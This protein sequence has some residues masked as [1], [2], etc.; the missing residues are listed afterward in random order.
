VTVTDSTGATAA[1]LV[2]GAVATDDTG[3][4]APADTNAQFLFTPMIR[5]GAGAW[6]WMDQMNRGLAD[7]L[8]AKTV[9]DPN[10]NGVDW[11]TALAGTIQ[12]SY[13][14]TAVTGVGT[15]F[16]QDFCG[17]GTAPLLWRRMVVWF[18]AGGES[19]RRAYD[20]AS[21][22]S[23][24]S[25]T[26]AAP[27][28]TTAGTATGL[29][30]SVMTCG[31]CWV[32]G[33]N[34][35]NYY[36]V[37]LSF[38]N[39]YQRSGRTQYLTYARQLAA[40]WWTQPYFDKTRTAFVGDDRGPKWLPPRSQSLIGLMWWAYET[41]QPGFWTRLYTLLDSTAV[42]V[43]TPGQLL[44]LREQAYQLAFLAVASRLAPDVAK[45]TQYRN[46]VQTAVTNKWLPQQNGSGAWV[47]RTFGVGTWNGGTGT[48]T[49]TNGSD[50]VTGAGTNWTQAWF[51]DAYLWIAYDANGLTGDTASY[52]GATV[53]SPTSIRLPRPYEGPTATGRF[54]TVSN[55][56][57]WGV[58]PFL[59]GLAGRLLDL[60]YRATGDAGLKQA[61]VQAGNWLVNF[62][63]QPTVRGLYYGR[64]YPPCEPAGINV[65]WCSY[66]PGTAQGINDARYNNSTIFGLLSVAYLYGGSASLKQASDD[67]AGASVGKS[68]GPLADTVNGL[69]IW[70]E[71]SPPGTLPI[72]RD[73]FKEFG[74]MFGVGMMPSWPAARLK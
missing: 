45:R 37:V 53:L 10:W 38:Y 43:V 39:L 71:T 12:V 67:L 27:Y 58:Q 1:D 20:V 74:Q 63:V 55:Q 47:I 68:G 30:Y 33:S 48:A 23:A 13:N 73:R 35:V 4:I 24:T 26:L 69:T 5:Y 29:S 59:H 56:P 52:Y 40:K 70:G 60:A 51:N 2:F 66:D 64:Y 22:N 50:M 46:A 28:L 44:E 17:G 32:W 72:F 19:G 41:Q 62:G 31:E 57:G 6:P 8:G 54:W 21:C 36:D 16:Q 9:S 65:R 25:I 42:D 15:N 14:S 11:S 49:V 7:E 18:P 3:A 34:N 61:I